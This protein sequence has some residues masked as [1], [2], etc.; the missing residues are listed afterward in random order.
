V[1][2]RDVEATLESTRRILDA[3]RELV[4]R[5]GAAE[6]SIGD[7]AAVA[8]VSK[9]LVHYHFHDKDSMLVA[10]A[11]AAGR[12]LVAR[13]EAA[14]AASSEAPLDAF[15]SWLREELAIGDLRVLLSLAAYDS[16]AVRDVARRVAQQRRRVGAAH[17]DAAFGQLGLRSR[18]PSLLLADTMMAFSDG[19]ASATALDVEHDPR[20]AFDVLWLALLSLAE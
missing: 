4:A 8:G 16:E 6:I 7:V 15:W 18:V 3:A 14:S 11:E 1:S 2:Q 10:L 5:G 9:A 12:D 20:P 13:E 17:I 19:L